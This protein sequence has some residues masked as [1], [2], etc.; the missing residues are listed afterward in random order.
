MWKVCLPV[1]NFSN[2]FEL[3]SDWFANIFLAFLVKMRSF[4]CWL[5]VWVKTADTQSIQFPRSWLRNPEFASKS[6]RF[7]AEPQ[8]LV[9][10]EIKCDLS[11]KTSLWLF[12]FNDKNIFIRQRRF[13]FGSFNLLLWLLCRMKVAKENESFLVCKYSGAFRLLDRWTSWSACLR[14]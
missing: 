6:F 1:L 10:N 11:E 8:V 5:K 9:Q 7:L 3:A 14:L 2:L 4:A 13:N 12:N